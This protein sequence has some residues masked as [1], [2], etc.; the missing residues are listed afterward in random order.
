MKNIY[1]QTIV[2]IGLGLSLAGCSDGSTNNNGNPPVSSTNAMS[3]DNVIN[4]GIGSDGQI[5]V[6]LDGSFFGSGDTVNII[7]ST[8]IGPSY[9]VTSDSTSQLLLEMPPMSDSCTFQVQNSGQ[10]SD[11]STSVALSDTQGAININYAY[12]RSSTG[13]SDNMTMYGLFT[14]SD[15]VWAS[16]D[17]A[18]QFSEVTNISLN[19]TNE[20]DFTMPTPISFNSCQ[21]FVDGNTVQ[22]PTFNVIAINKVSDNGFNSSTTDSITL[23]GLFVGDGNDVV[24]SSCDGASGF[25]STSNF[26]SDTTSQIEISIPTPDN[27]ASCQFYVANNQ[28]QSNIYSILFIQGVYELGFNTTTE[29]FVVEGVFSGFN[30][31][32][33]AACDGDSFT[34]YALSLDSESQ[35]KFAMPTPSDVSSCQMYVQNG[36]FQTPIYSLGNLPTG[37]PLHSLNQKKV[38][39]KKVK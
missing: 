37:I 23:K 8:N 14:G 11:I 32:V 1:V 7:C 5:S 31:Q 24:Y 28:V 39:Q 36:T 22:S 4:Y 21:F 6:E 29:N 25:T 13:S 34:Q 9:S 12:D 33:W 20:I 18:A 26:I 19:N 16:C 15:D 17:G 2:L 38:L 3:I 35:L 30:D 27:F 10:T